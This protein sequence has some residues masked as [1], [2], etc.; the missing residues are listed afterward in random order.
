MIEMGLKSLRWLVE[1]QTIEGRFSPIGNRGWYRRGGERAHYDQQPIEA[2]ALV[3]ACACAF[4]VTNDHSWLEHVMLGFEWFLG[5]ND[6][7]AVLYDD[8][9]GG[10][11]DGLD[12]TGASENE[13]AE[14]MLAWLSV[15]INMNELQANGH[16]GW[17]REARTK[18][19]ESSGAE[20]AAAPVS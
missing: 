1:I 17:T 10:C 16:L 13:G 7:N 15:L 4:D 14:S 2:D 9:T 18:Q 8:A 3:S 6:L 19:A 5:R 20:S 11:R 12:A